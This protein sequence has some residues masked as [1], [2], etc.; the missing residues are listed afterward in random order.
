MA[1]ESEL[2]LQSTARLEVAWFQDQEEEELWVVE[3]PS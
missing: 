3:L 2:Q 1:S